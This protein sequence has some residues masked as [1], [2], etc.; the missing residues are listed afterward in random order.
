MHQKKLNNI[1]K[2]LNNMNDILD[3]SQYIP[4]ECAAALTILRAVQR[5]FEFDTYDEYRTFVD[6]YLD[7]HSFL[8]K[9][10]KADKFEICHDVK[11][12]YINHTAFYTYNDGYGMEIS[13]DCSTLYFGEIRAIEREFLEWEYID[14]SD[15]DYNRASRIVGSII[16]SLGSMVQLVH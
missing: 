9:N 15:K 12:D 5:G 2:N 11:V 8:V 16:D 4:T 7:A 1:L 14:S 3:L 6:V 13:G 10:F